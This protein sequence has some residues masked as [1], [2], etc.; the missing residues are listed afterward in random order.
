MLW[1]HGG[2]MVAGSAVQS[3]NG[4]LV[5]DGA[6]FARQGMVL[7]S[8]NY[9]LGS[10][11]FLAQRDL[12]GEAADHPQTGNYGLLDQIAALRWVADNIANFGGDPAQVTIFGESA[13]GVSSCA[14]LAAPAARGLFA[15]AIVQSGNC[16]WA[17]RDLATGLVQG[18][19]VTAAAGCATAVD[20]RACLRALSAT[21]LLDAVPPVIDPANMLDGESFGLVVDGFVLDQAP[22][23]AIAAGNAAPAPLLIGVNDDETTTLVPASMLPASVAGYEAAIRARFPA[24][25]TEVLQRYPAVQYATPQRAYQDLLDDL[26]FTCAAR[27]AAADH[28]ARGNPVFHYALTE[29]LP[30]P[31][32]AALE[33]FH[34]LD[35]VLLFG[36]L[37]PATPAVR[38]LGARMQRAWIDFAHGR[39]PGSSDSIAWPRYQLPARKSLEFNSAGVPLINDY[40]GEQCAFWNRYVV[41]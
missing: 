30:D 10:L 15:R 40:R 6:A 11:G 18:E 13:G 24:I 5:Y 19:R 35:V 25:A 32:L 27:R 22:G 9:R 34:G 31:G 16:S 12:I 36:D 21:Q 1:I 29:I 23:P 20:R 39:E 41:L 33:S 8:I 26:L 14:L 4:R 38:A 7:V 37:T 2:G 17:P 3:S 28:A